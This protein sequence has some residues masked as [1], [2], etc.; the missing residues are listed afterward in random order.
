[1]PNA[2]SDETKV[3]EELAIMFQGLF[4]SGC[5]CFRHYFASPS[6]IMYASDRI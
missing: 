4:Q 5:F 1:M 6:T 2:S 3:S